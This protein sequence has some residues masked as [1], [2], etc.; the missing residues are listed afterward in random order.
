MLFSRHVLAEIFLTGSAGET[1]GVFRRNC[2][3]RSEVKKDCRGQP[4]S[5]GGSSSVRTPISDFI[6]AKRRGNYGKI[7]DSKIIGGKK[8]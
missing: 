7:M 4:I 5:F 8:S 3:N 1:G 6:A 2:Q